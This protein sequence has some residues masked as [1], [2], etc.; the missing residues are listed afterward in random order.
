MKE[1]TYSVITI[2][3]FEDDGYITEPDFSPI[4]IMKRKDIENK[5]KRKELFIQKIKKE[6]PKY[7]IIFIHKNLQKE[8][9]EYHKKIFENLTIIK[10]IREFETI[11]KLLD[12]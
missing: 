4:F 6:N 8:F 3:E 11:D 5:I 7:N 9:I 12:L 2:I 1:K 10:T